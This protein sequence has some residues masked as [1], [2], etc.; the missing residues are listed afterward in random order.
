M[1]FIKTICAIRNHRLPEWLEKKIAEVLGE[2]EGKRVLF[3][4]ETERKVRSSEQN[5]FYWGIVLPLIHAMF[6]DAGN[7]VS[8]EDVHQYLKLHVGRLVKDIHDT[9]G[10]SKPIARSSTNLTTKEWEDWL[11]NIRAWAAPLGVQVPLPN[12]LTYVD[13]SSLQARTA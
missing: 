4:I 12:E 8:K 5:R 7:V 13:D 11:T 10:E 2:Q 9:E 6:T 1:V 3:T